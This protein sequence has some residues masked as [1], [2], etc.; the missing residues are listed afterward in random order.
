MCGIPSN[1]LDVFQQLP[2]DENTYRSSLSI[3]P[4]KYMLN[5]LFEW[6]WSEW[7]DNFNVGEFNKQS[8]TVNYFQS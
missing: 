5:S 3:E 1:H 8:S 2:Y 6:H 7:R 4:K